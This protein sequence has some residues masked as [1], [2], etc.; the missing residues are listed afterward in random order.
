MPPTVMVK[1]SVLQKQ[2]NLVVLQK[3]EL[4]TF[5]W[6]DKRVVNFLNPADRPDQCDQVKRK[7]DSMHR[8]VPSHVVVSSDNAEMNA[9]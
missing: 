7:K 8:M 1:D 6:K 4:V 5:R 3:G 9:V 2:G